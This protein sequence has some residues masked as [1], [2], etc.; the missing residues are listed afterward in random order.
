MDEASASSAR[1]DSFKA[2][3][4]VNSSQQDNSSPKSSSYAP[5]FQFIYRLEDNPF[6][7]SNANTRYVHYFFS[8]FGSA[9]AVAEQ[10]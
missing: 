4:G 8:A 1:E 9:A 10:R 2:L 3:L 6:I 5:C 7:N